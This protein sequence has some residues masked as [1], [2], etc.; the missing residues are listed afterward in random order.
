MHRQPPHF[1]MHTPHHNLPSLTFL[2]LVAQPLNPGTHYLFPQSCLRHRPNLSG[3]SAT[4]T[5]LPKRPVSHP[6]QLPPSSAHPINT[7]APFPPLRSLRSLMAVPSLATVFPHWLLWQPPGR[8]PASS[9]PTPAPP[10]AL[11][12]LLGSLHSSRTSPRSLRRSSNSFPQL[13]IDAILIS[14]SENQ[15]RK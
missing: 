15:K 2:S 4:S 14:V 12:T 1:S 11:V 6:Y 9:Y 3:S 10:F 5:Q 7:L 8:S 13:R